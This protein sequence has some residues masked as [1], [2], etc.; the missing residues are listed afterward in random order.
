MGVI[1]RAKPKVVIQIGDALDLYAFSKFPRSYNV[2]TP[3][4]EMKKGRHVLEDFWKA[5]RGAAGKSADL[6]QLKGN[7]DSRMAKR[8]IAALPEFESF[9]GKCSDLWEFPGVETVAAERDELILD[10][11]CYMHGYRKH[12]DHVRY[13][14]MSTVC[15]HS[16]VGG[17]IYVPH[18]GQTLF[19]LNAGYLGNAKTTALSYTNQA[20]ISKWTLGVGLIDSW[21]PRFIPVGK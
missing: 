17:V 8:M 11:I 21:G 3:A 10:D 13:N 6:Y 5:I 2:M 12:G 20:K 16:H 1:R 14:L 9:L 7:H 18:K 15:G 4:A 19:E